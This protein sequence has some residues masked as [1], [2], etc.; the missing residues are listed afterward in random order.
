MTNVT[1]P[2]QLRVRRFQHE[3]QQFVDQLDRDLEATGLQ[4]NFEPLR[5][6]TQ[7]RRTSLT[8][9]DGGRR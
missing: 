6:Q 1:D 7:P 5:G 8:V 3:A 9:I 2:G 4:F